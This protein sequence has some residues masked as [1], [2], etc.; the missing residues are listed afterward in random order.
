MQDTHIRESLKEWRAILK[1]YQA[2]DT[3][4]AVI[5]ILNSFGPFVALCILMYFSLDWSYFI[6]LGLALINSFFLVRIFIIQHDCGHQS[7]LHSKKWNN[8]IG[9]ISSFCS[10]IPYKYWSKT[11]NAHHTHNGQL[12]HR[13]LGDIYYLTTDEYAKLTW[14]GKLGYRIFRNPFFQFIL[15]PTVY[16]VISLR[17]PFIRLKGW[18]RIRWSYFMN[19]V[20]ILLFYGVLIY[21]FGWKKILLV[22][23]PIV[24]IFGIIA[25]W[26][27]YVQHQHEDN[28]KEH[29]EKWDHLLASI[30]GS[31]YYKLPKLFQWLSGNIGFHHIHHLNPRIP[32]YNL[33]ACAKENPIINKFVNIITFKD[34]LKCI[35]YK[36]WDKQKQKMI[37]FREYAQIMAQQSVK[38]ANPM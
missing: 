11:H 10:T 14:Y 34:S 6:T 22:H 13:G 31:T 36:L 4:K 33:E 32:N 24:F 2:P 37:T 3:K 8:V 7:F 35:H 19:N 1:K 23:I 18:K 29:K 9:F 38:P 28:Y 25:F 16:L 30:K 21:F 5:Q 20:A 17:Y 26:F 15:A 27:F 12:E